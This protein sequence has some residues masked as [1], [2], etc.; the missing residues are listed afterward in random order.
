[1]PEDKRRLLTL[2]DVT[3]TAKETTLRAGYHLPT[4]IV[5]GE[6]RSIVGQIEQLAD[7]F[8]EREA[9]MFVQ[10]MAVAQMGGMGVLQQVFFISEG[11][12]SVRS[13]DAPPS[14]PPSQDPQRKE[15][16]IVA[17]HQVQSVKNTG[18]M[19]EMRRNVKG[20]LIELPALPMP[21]AQ[22]DLDFRNPL[23]EAFVIGFL[24]SAKKLD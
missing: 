7:T 6:R 3:C 9:Q 2:D 8:E 13:K 11:W 21:D 14:L 12:M 5:E 18:V 23:L 15:V 19:F 1:M 24:G 17:H 10:G 4:V 16:L 22:T 20:K